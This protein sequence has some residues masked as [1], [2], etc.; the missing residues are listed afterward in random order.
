MATQPNRAPREVLDFPANTPVTVALKY[1]QGKSVSTQYGQRVMFSLADGRIMFLDPKVGR[2][3]ASLGIRVGENFNITKRWNGE[4]DSPCSWELARVAG[5]QPN[6]TLVL[7]GLPS[8]PPST[9]RKPATKAP[10]PLIDEANALIDAYAE[11]LDRTLTTYP[12]RIKP[13]DARFLLITAYTQRSKLA[14]VA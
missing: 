7:P 4:K 3:I 1:A 13:S 5:E 14:S 12:G 10:S 2:Q 9:A 8:S 6:G 11:V